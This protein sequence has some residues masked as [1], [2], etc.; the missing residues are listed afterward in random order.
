MGERIEDSEIKIVVEFY[1]FVY[2]IDFAFL[3]NEVEA[4]LTP[5]PP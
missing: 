4:N 3:I 2:D 1:P 5:S